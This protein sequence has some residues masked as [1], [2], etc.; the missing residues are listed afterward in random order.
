MDRA[1][2]PKNC[3]Y[4]PVPWFSNKRSSFNYYYISQQ[5]A[6]NVRAKATVS[7]YT[8]CKTALYMR[9]LWKLVLII[10]IKLKRSKSLQP[11][12]NRKLVCSQT[13]KLSDTDS[14]IFIY[15]FSSNRY[16]RVDFWQ[17]EGV[18]ENSTPVKETRMWARSTTP[19]WETWWI[20]L[21]V[22]LTNLGSLRLKPSVIKIHLQKSTS[23]TAEFQVFD[24]GNVICV[25]LYAVPIGNYV[26][27]PKS[28]NW[29]SILF[30]RNQAGYMM[31]QAVMTFLDQY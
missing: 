8:V 21:E 14:S 9:H 18:D 25:L 4:C 31:Y 7:K 13:Y 26:N 16:Y 5:F 20:A 2:L 12:S 1:S 6:G 30:K 23:P 22:I 3:V 28:K 15:L 27:S 17:Q 19:V 11:W 10:L 24:T 29:F